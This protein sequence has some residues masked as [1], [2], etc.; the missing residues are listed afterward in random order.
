M[1]GKPLRARCWLTL[2]VNNLINP[3]QGISI[4]ASYSAHFTPI[5][6]PKLHSDIMNQTVSNPAAPEMPYVV[7]LYA[8]DFLSTIDSLAN[9]DAANANNVNRRVGHDRYYVCYGIRNSLCVSRIVFLSPEPIYA[10]LISV[11]VHHP[12]YV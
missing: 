9:A 1:K 3:V 11:A 6:A 2:I 10:P 12:E 8:I 4:P 5:S 7:I